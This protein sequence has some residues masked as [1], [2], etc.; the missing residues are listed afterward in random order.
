MRKQIIYVFLAILFSLPIVKAQELNIDVKVSSPINTTVDAKL[1]ETLEKSIYEFLNNTQGTDD[2]Y[3]VLERING[4]IQFTIVEEKSNNSFVAD[5]I[6]QSERPVFN[7]IYVTPMLNYIDKGFKFNYDLLQPIQRSD[8]VYIDQLSSLL[9]YYV[10]VILAFD[11]DSFSSLGGED[12]WRAAQNVISAI[13]SGIT[14]NTGWDSGSTNV[15]KNRYWLT[16]NMLNPKVR[17]Y[18]QSMYDYHRLGL[19][20]MYDNPA[21]A[22]IVMLNAVMSYGEVNSNYTNSMVMRM[23]ADSKRDEMIE[24]FKVGDK[25]QKSKVRSTMVK[26]DPTQADKYNIL[27]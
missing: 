10:Y 24:V 2:Q 23:L 21:R 7:S 3:E 25:G 27:K 20:T 14:N 9:T 17:L 18:R 13:P 16:E 5:I 4:T 8:N 22:R 19:D 15:R 11:Y 6:V 12:H 26:I 1:F